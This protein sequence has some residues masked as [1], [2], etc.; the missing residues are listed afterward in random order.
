[1]KTFNVLPL[2][3]R[4]LLAWLLCAFAHSAFAQEPPMALPDAM[5]QDVEQMAGMSPETPAEPQAAAPAEGA[6]TRFNTRFLSFGG[7]GET[8]AADLAAF[9]HGNVLTPGEHLVGVTMNDG[10]ASQYTLNFQSD[11]AS[12]DVLP[13]LT[14]ALL[15]E[16]GANLS[17][18]PQLAGQ[19]AAACIDLHAVGPNLSVRVDAA[20]QT[21][22]ITIPQAMMKRSAQG[23]ID[24]AH[25][26]S[27]IDSALFDYRLSASKNYVSSSRGNGAEWYASLRSGLNLGGWRFRGDMSLNRD[28]SGTHV[29]MPSA[30]AQHDITALKSQLTVGDSFMPG[31]V[32][33]SV[34]FRGVQLSSDDAMQP[35]SLRGYAPIVRGIAQSHAKV[36]IRQNG[37]LVYSTYV[38]PGPF[39]IDDMYPASSNSD[40]EVTII[41]ADGQK[42]SF[43]QPYANI[44]TLLREH[45]LKYHFTAGV[46]RVPGAARHASFVAGTAAY[47]VG[48]EITLY[49]GVIASPLYT[50]LALGAAKNMAVLGALSVDVTHARSRLPD[51]GTESGQSMRVMYAKALDTLG[52][53]FRTAAY[54]YSTKGY[55]S[56]RDVVSP[57]PS[58]IGAAISTD[59]ARSRVEATVT[60]ALGKGGHY[61]SMYASY[62]QQSYWRRPGNDRV[63]QLGY[64]SSLKRIPYRV[65]FSSDR[66]AGGK[67][68]RQASFSVS[69]PLGGSA[70]STTYANASITSGEAGTEQHAG[71][72]GTV[73]DDHRFSYSVDT[74][75]SPNGGMSGNASVNYRT[76]VGEFGVAHNQARDYSQTTL[77]ASGGVIV[78]GRGVTFGQSLGETNVLVAAPGAGQVGIESNS[79]VRTDSRGFAIVPSATPYRANRV[80]L[81]TEDLDRQA[82][83]KAATV[84]V[85]PRRGAVVLAPFEIA[86]GR[87]LLNIRNESGEPMPFGARIFDADR[88][89]VGMVGPDGQGFVTGAGDAATLTVRWGKQMREACQLSFDMTSLAEASDLP[90]LDVVCGAARREADEAP[91]GLAGDVERN[92]RSLSQ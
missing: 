40:M 77:D 6:A 8:S 48:H 47:G 34:P 2:A 89:E 41:E 53:E 82:A 69:I 1:M 45:G 56:F 55:H 59:G 3:A 19:D 35:D 46:T 37:F 14:P 31:D 75:R 7:D 83:V 57:T 32:F 64:S 51:G 73:F 88:H 15:D 62:T 20:T 36:E 13:C 49:G 78:H 61:G 74:N 10:T 44:P 63:I 11:A 81:R 5:P 27:G 42:R 80:A 38:P 16:L 85:V 23:A 12:G 66:P 39:V 52:T 79:G 60:Q 68:S 25:W 54:R 21:V 22:A 30:Y 90:E 18:F 58:D 70:S 33:D 67:A 76:S 43:M 92:F 17:A 87:L 28:Y 86:K 29:Q 65:N 50:A 72:F 4:L 84:D 9:A 26:N 91:P 24:P 71:L